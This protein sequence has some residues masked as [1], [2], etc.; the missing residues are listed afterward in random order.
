MAKQ[1]FIPTDDMGKVPFLNTFAAKKEEHM[2]LFGFDAPSVQ[3]TKDDAAIFNHVMMVIDS[4]RTDSKEFTKYKDL[5]RDGPNNGILPPFPTQSPIPAAPTLVLADIFGRV[6]KD[7][8][9]IKAHVNY[10][11]VL[12]QEFGIIGSESTFDAATFK[13]KLKLRVVG[14]GI[15]T[16]FLKNRTDG[17]NLSMRLAGSSTWTKVGLVTHSPYVDTT[18]LAQPGVPEKREYKGRG[19]IKNIEIGLDSDIVLITYGG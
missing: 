14:T 11:E 5:L 7:A 16:K 8:A 13:T 3:Q 1:P 18:P 10:T 19:V 17:I 6:S 9:A 4:I 15:E 2:V 12:G